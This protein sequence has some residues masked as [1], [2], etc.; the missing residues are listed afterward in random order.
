MS[1]AGLHPDFKRASAQP[2]QLGTIFSRYSRAVCKALL[3]TSWPGEHRKEERHPLVTWGGRS[4]AREGA[5]E[6]RGTAGAPQ[7]PHAEHSSDG[8]QQPARLTAGINRPRCFPFAPSHSTQSWKRA[9]TSLQAAQGPRQAGRHAELTHSPSIYS[10][11]R[12]F[13]GER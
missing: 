11:S 13:P 1:C 2:D 7:A 12:D 10:A 8:S 9:D 6:L 3:Q 4:E 5:D